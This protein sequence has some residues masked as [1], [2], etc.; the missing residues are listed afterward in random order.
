M[1][2]IKLSSRLLILIATLWLT[3][4]YCGP[5]LSALNDYQTSLIAQIG[6][7]FVIAC[8]YAVLFL[9]ARAIN[10]TG[11]IVGCNALLVGLLICQISL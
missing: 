7:L 6:F 1:K 2:A 3:L 4:A 8:V 10:S 5:L 9:I 11:F